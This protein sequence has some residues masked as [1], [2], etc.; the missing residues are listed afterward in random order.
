[1][2]KN[3]L[4]E[5]QLDTIIKFLQ[6]KFEPYLIVLFGSAAQGKLRTDSDIDLA[7]LSDL[8]FSEYDIFMRARKKDDYRKEW[9]GNPFPR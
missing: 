1:M 8:T 7:F 2:D 5:D 3:T 6:T 9:N 4:H